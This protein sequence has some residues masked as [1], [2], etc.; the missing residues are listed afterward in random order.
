VSGAS[1]Q[2]LVVNQPERDAEVET[3][4]TEFTKLKKGVGVSNGTAV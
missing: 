1:L 4:F 2:W 3:E